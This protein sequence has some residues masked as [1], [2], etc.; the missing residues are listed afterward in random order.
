M[1]GKKKVTKEKPLDKMTSKELREVAKEID[2]IVGVHGMNKTELISSIKKSR[3][4]IE[5]AGSQKSADVRDI[6]Q[7]IKELKVKYEAAA[8]KEDSKMTAIF[9]K[10][11]INLKKK[12]RK[13]A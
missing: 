8:K 3:G 10:K 9:R 4:I 6:K 2:G 12:T 11:I 13:A 5:T 1:A 7:K